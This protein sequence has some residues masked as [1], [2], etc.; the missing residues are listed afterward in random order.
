MF[1][2]LE[3]H[4]LKPIILVSPGSGGVKS[5]GSLFLKQVLQVDV[6]RG[7]VEVLECR[8]WKSTKKCCAQ[9]CLFVLI[10]NK[11]TD[12]LVSGLA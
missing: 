7:V 1:L 10:R 5:G 8:C 2:L 11:A 6:G 3:F 4:P 9:L 12:I